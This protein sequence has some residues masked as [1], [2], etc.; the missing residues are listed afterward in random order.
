MF[1]RVG[2]GHLYCIRTEFNQLEFQEGGETPAAFISK[3]S[4]LQH[5]SERES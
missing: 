2:F 3:V 4:S 1:L 5:S